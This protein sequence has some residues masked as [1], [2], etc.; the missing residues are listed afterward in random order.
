[1]PGDG[2]GRQ[3]EEVIGAW[4]EPDFKFSGASQL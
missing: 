1:M 3:Q 4:G 2:A